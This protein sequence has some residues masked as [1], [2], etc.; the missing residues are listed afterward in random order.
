MSDPS[1]DC[2]YLILICYISI[3]EQTTENN[4]TET[5]QIIQNDN[6]TCEKDNGNIN[7]FFD[8]FIYFFPHHMCKYRNI[9]KYK[10]ANEEKNSE[11]MMIIKKKIM[12]IKIKM[13]II[14]IKMMIIKI[15]M[16]IIKIIMMIIKIKIMIIK[17]IIIVI[18]M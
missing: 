13:M 5:N 6:I 18:N 4:K 17:I 15:I 14:K 1:N 10:F 3:K 12:I 2:P 11:Q 16:M 8:F 9:E 7:N